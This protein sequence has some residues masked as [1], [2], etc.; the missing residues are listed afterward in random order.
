MADNADKLRDANPWHPMNDPIDIK[1]IGK[2]IEELGECVSAAA[3]V[4]IQGIEECEPVTKKPN[5]EWLEDEIADIKANIDLCV[6]RFKLSIN[7]DRE[8]RKKKYLKQWHD[9]A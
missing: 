9:L 4:L 6:D 5:K 7:K 3:R 1:H 8:E 2:F